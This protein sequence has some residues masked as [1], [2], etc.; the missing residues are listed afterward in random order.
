MLE[1]IRELHRTRSVSHAAQNLGLSQ[2]AVSMSLARLRTHFT[3]PLF[4]RTSQGM[5]PTPYAADLIVD[6]QRAADILASAMD[7]RAHF[8]PRTSDRMFHLISTDIAQFTVLPVL[9]NKLATLAPSVRIDLNLLTRRSPRQLE[10]GEANLAI[11]LIPQMGAGFCQQKL[12][13]GEFLCAVRTRHPRIRSA[14]TLKQFQEEAHLSVTT[15]GTG[16][17]TLEKSIESQHI[18]RNI[19]MRV[20][21]FLGVTAIIEVTDYVVIVPQRFGR[22]L[23]ERGGL[24]LFPLPFPFPAYNV[25]QNWHERYTHDPAQR[26]FRNVILTMFREEPARVLLPSTP[27]PRSRRL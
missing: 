2:S 24:K 9:V 11:G 16:Y 26:W 20:P 17:E 18:Q 25:T 12:F 27:V 14:L 21:S 10:S 8:D 1:V 19:G 4:V 22:V 15:L 6:L 23:A 3:D 13:S 7:R 5:E